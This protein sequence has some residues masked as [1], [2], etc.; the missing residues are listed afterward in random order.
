MNSSPA[1]RETPLGRELA[2]RIAERG[3]MTFAEYMEECL[4]NPAHGYYSRPERTRF[5]DYY[6]SV[7][8]HPIFGRL[9]ARQLEQMWRVLDRPAPF[10]VVESGAGVG[11]LAAHILDFSA[12][13]LPE[14]YDAL[15]YVAVERSAARRAAHA[16]ALFAHL[17]SGHA[18]SSGVL[19]A[20][21]PAGCLLSNEMFDAMPVHRVLQQAGGL[22]EIYA[23]VVGGKLGDTPGPI[24]T[25]R[26][27][28]YF[29]RLGITLKEGQQ[30]EA[31][32]AACDW[33]ADAAEHLESR[34]HTYGGLR[35]L[36]ARSVQRAAH[37][38]HV[39]R[40]SRSSGERRFLRRARRAGFNGARQFHGAGNLGQR[41]RV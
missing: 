34:I 33:I 8:V 26:L 38:R 5:A 9:L 17:A 3:P 4:Y 20:K 18:E 31:G 37:A 29:H 21:I 30:A 7:D 1:I 2:A 35:L 28:D 24:S 19:P 36:C 13:H 11:R 23:G 39:A 27:T 32:L 22:R 15:Q 10:S 41:C 6:T 16:A 40:L 12:A 14:F 25:P